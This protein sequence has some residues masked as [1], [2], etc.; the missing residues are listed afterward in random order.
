ML[1]YTHNNNLKGIYD[2]SEQSFLWHEIFLWE[3]VDNV[4]ST[5]SIIEPK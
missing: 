5:Y 2:L 1:F 4:R 3:N